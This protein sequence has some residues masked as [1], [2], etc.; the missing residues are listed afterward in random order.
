[1]LIKCG[2]Y[3]RIRPY[4]CGKYLEVRLHKCDIEEMPGRWSL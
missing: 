1:M 2:P 4:K 3:V